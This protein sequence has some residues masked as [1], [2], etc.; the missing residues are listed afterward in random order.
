M[1]FKLGIAVLA[2]ALSLTG[3]Q[4]EQTAVASQ[5]SPQVADGDTSPPQYSHRLP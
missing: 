2:I 3:R 1:Y 5:H 4:Q